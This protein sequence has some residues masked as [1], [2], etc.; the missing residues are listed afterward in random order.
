MYAIVNIAG[1]Q[2]KVE[3]GDIVHVPKLETSSGEQVNFDRV[4]LLSHGE[5]E[6]LTGH[7][8]VTQAKVTGKVLSHGRGDK[9]LVFKKKRRK[10]Y[11]KLNGHRQG[12][13]EVLIEDILIEG[14]V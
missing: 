12:Y 6:L 4:L 5:G 9:I 2:L 13:T 8:I 11:E 14:E 7:P 1:S 3:K 10:G